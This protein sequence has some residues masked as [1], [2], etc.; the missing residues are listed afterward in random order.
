M[1]QL[2]VFALS[3]LAT[4]LLTAWLLHRQKTGQSPLP[5]LPSLSTNADDVGNSEYEAQPMKGRPIL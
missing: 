3:N 4:M 2:I 5:T 1:G